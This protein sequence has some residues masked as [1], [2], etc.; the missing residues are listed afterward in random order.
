MLPGQHEPGSW[1]TVPGAE[2]LPC[3]ARMTVIAASPGG[4]NCL[5]PYPPPQAAGR[6]P[7]NSCL[8]DDA[9]M[10][11]IRALRG[12]AS[13]PG[14]VP[15]DPG[16]CCPGNKASSKVLPGK[17]GASPFRIPARNLCGKPQALNT[18]QS[19]SPCSACQST[20]SLTGPFHA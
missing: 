8:P 19:H 10:T 6:V 16:S 17:H 18:Y 7:G 5:A 12:D 1:G 9:A 4:T 14:T 3:S 15:Q 13:T 20:N 2:A 11:V